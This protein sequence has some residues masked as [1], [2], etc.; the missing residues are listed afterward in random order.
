MTDTTASQIFSGLGPVCAVVGES[1]LYYLYLRLL[2]SGL[3]HTRHPFFVAMTTELTSRIAISLL[4]QSKKVFY[5]LNVQYKKPP[6]VV[7]W[8]RNNDGRKEI[9]SRRHS[10]LETK[11][12]GK[13]RPVN[14][15]GRTAAPTSQ[16]VS[17]SVLVDVHLKRRASRASRA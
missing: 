9:A 8:G 7:C 14:R 15:P 4:G 12:T 17:Q 5:L 16:S 2:R 10:R 13:D 6:Q 1:V 3:V 11:L